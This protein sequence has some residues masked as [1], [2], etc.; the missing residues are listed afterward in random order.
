MKKVIV[1]LVVTSLFLTS[2]SV[3]H[4]DDDS[5]TFLFLETHN[6]SVW[7]RTDDSG[8]KHYLRILA[9]KNKVAKIYIGN[10]DKNCFKTELAQKV[11]DRTIDDDSVSRLSLYGY[12]EYGNS[13]NF[14]LDII[15]DELHERYYWEVVHNTGGH[16]RKWVRSE[17]NVEDLKKCN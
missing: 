15:D 5:D 7:E 2:C 6:L 3:I 13:A 9:D 17:V 10:R 1:L 8:Q 12:D 14:S 11:N 4:W 16:T